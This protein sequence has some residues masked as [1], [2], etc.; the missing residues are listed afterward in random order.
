MIGVSR[1]RSSRIMVGLIIMAQT[2][3][4]HA[5]QPTRFNYQARLTGSGGTALTGTHTLTFW[6]FEGGTAAGAGSGTQKYKETAA[7]NI[8]N[9]LAS[10][11]V[12]TGTP[13]GPP[14]ISSVFSTSSD[15]FLQ[16][17]V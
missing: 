14:L 13:S 4:L 16:V 5:A 12:G 1:M 8:Q 15:L 7:V 9:G 17:A 2:P 6:I 3:L 10:F 11:A